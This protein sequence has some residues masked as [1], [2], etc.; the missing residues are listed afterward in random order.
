MCHRR[1]GIERVSFSRFISIFDLFLVGKCGLPIL[2]ACKTY[3]SLVMERTDNVQAYVLLDSFR[4]IDNYIR[5][6]NSLLSR[7][8]ARD[9]PILVSIFLVSIPQMNPFSS[10]VNIIVG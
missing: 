4:F 5:D 7:W 1:C 6:G 10:F 3:D 9:F 2:R 8:F